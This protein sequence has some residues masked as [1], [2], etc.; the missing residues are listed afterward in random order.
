MNEQDQMVQG[1]APDE[2]LNEVELIGRIPISRRTL[3]NW[4]NAGKIPFVQIPGSRRVLYHWPSV[5]LVLLRTQHSV[6]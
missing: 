6:D 2:F 4:R 5:L 3:T 1:K